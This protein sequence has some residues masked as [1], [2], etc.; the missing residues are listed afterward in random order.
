MWIPKTADEI[1]QVLASRELRETPSFDGKR[2]IPSSRD[3]ATDVAAMATDGGVLLIGVG[4]D[5][6][7][8]LSIPSP[9]ELAGAPE[10]VDQMIATNISEPPK[11]FIHRIE[12]PGDPAH[13]YLVI[14]VPQS[15]RAPHMVTTKGHNLYYGRGETGNRV[16][17]EGDVSRLYDR[18]ARFEVDRGVLLQSEI[19]GSPL[20]PNPEL[21]YLHMFVR[22]AAPD[23]RLLARA[24]PAL[25]PAGSDVQQAL[26]AL[27]HEA[28]QSDVLPPKYQGYPKCSEMAHH[29]WYR[30]QTGYRLGAPPQYRD[31]LYT[32]DQAHV[33]EIVLD[34]D[35]TAHLL[36]GRAAD[37]MTRPDSSVKVIIE[38]PI[39]AHAVRFLW[40]AGRLYNAAG[41]WGAVDVGLAIT[42]IHGA[43]ALGLFQD[44][45]AYDRVGDTY[46]GSDYRRTR[47]CSQA[48]LH[49]DTAAVAGSLLNPLFETLTQGRYDP[50]ALM[51]SGQAAA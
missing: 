38:V 34:E 8:V 21:G 45:I 13:G 43:V 39:T 19:G 22:P 23:E 24:V 51:L 46:R 20:A 35:G 26:A 29:R 50:F 17:A 37:T 1:E 40:L 28:S 31:R 10:R 42:R 44:Y 49:T 33:L 6:H 2:E 25:G 32:E 9:I 14:V 41:Y 12:C 48:E 5:E 27:H 3:L 11:V 30:T 7:G 16:L 36:A 18:R 15:E 47:R 4:E